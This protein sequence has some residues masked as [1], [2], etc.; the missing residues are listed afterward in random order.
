VSLA[1]AEA[2]MAELVA[3]MTAEG[4]EPAE[5]DRIKTRIRA[6]ET[7]ALD[8]LHRRARR[9]GVELTSGL[10]LDDSR[11]WPAALAAVTPEDVQVAAAAVFRTE[12]SVT[13]WLMAADTP[14]LMQ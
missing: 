4:P 13:G 5:L 11:A 14:E 8:N 6:A 10:T 7:Y 1:E 3:R 2:R 9:I 12:Y